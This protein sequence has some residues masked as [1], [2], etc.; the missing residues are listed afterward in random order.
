MIDTS[1]HFLSTETIKHTIDGLLYNKMNILHWHIV[2][3][4]SFPL[5]VPERPDLSAYGKVGG[6]YSPA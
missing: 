2:D 3:E 6:T 4:D 1:R 5:E